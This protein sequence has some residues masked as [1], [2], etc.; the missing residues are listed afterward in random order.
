M[1]VTRALEAMPRLEG[2]FSLSLNLTDTCT[3]QLSTQFHHKL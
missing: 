1:I 3:T 2:T